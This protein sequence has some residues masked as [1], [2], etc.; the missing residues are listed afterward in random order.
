[1]SQQDESQLIAKI[2][3][4]VAEHAEFYGADDGASPAETVL[5]VAYREA[6]ARISQLSEAL[7]VATAARVEHEH[8]RERE[9]ADN[10]RLKIA[11]T[12][13]FPDTPSTAEALARKV[14]ALIEEARV[15]RELS[16][17]IADNA[18][19][20]FVLTQL[21]PRT[22]STAEAL[23][24]RVDDLILDQRKLDQL[25]EVLR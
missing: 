5:R 23:L 22:P 16:R 9:I 24:R 17:E 3:K 6:C 20:K 25:R 4:V 7:R 12:K 18:Q 21:F 13:L 15:A 14:E 1:M 19:L 8:E 11:L 10:V 2:A